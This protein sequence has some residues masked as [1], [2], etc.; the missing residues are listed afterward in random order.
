MT[1]PEIKPFWDDSEAIESYR[2]FSAGTEVQFSH[3]RLLGIQIQERVFFPWSVFKKTNTFYLVDYRF[4]EA[5]RE[6]IL[7]HNGKIIDGGDIYD[8][9]PGAIYA[10]F[11]NDDDNMLRFIA[12]SQIIIKHL[13]QCQH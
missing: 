1:Y 7:R 11:I 8:D 5:E 6:M 9:T 2:Y 12:E 13:I 10:Q 3:Y 4:T